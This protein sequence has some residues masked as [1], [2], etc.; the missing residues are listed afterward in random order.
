MRIF[1]SLIGVAIVLIAGC[2]ASPPAITDDPELNERLE[3]LI[4]LEGQRRL[5][6]FVLPESDDF[7]RIPQDPRNPLTSEKIRLG[8]LLFHDPTLSQSPL[9]ESSRGTYSCAT[10]HHAKAGFQAGRQQS[11]GDGGSGWGERGEARRPDPRYPLLDV[12]TPPLRSPS[13]LNTAYQRV[14]QWSGGAGANGP[15]DETTGFWSDKGVTRVNHLGYDGLETQAILAMNSHRMDN[16]STSVV[17]TNSEYQ[18]LWNQVFPGEPVS[19]EKVGLAIG[20]YERTIMASQAPFQRWLKGETNAMTSQEKRGALVFFGPS[21]CSDC[22]TGPALSSMAFYALGMKDMAGPDVFNS[23][24]EQLG[25]GEF[26]TTGTSDYKFKVPQLYNMIDSPF[27][28][29]GGTFKSIREVVD[30]YHRGIPEQN[31]PPGTVTDQFK[32]LVLT[33]DDLSDLTVFLTTALRDPDLGRYVPSSVP[34]GGCIP[35]NDAQARIDLGC[36]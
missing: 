13:V 34:S 1:K 33:P 6:N 9:Y 28:G 27:L 3:S 14:M 22:H 5:D 30:Y 32:P 8:Q 2:D 7:A 12:D 24:P 16:A 19:D 20:A 18:A 26:L 17:A 11:I 23:P 10:C 25:R 4:T 35:A 29:H 21:A 36:N 31:L 15:N